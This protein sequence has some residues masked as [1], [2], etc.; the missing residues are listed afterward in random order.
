[1]SAHRKLLTRFTSFLLA[2]TMLFTFASASTDINQNGG[3]STTGVSGQ[4][5]W[6]GDSFIRVTLLFAENADWEK[7]PVYQVGR[8]VD[9]CST[10]C[11][12]EYEVKKA[13]DFSIK[14][15]LPGFEVTA[16]TAAAYNSGAPLK[17]GN[18][19]YKV[20]SE[21]LPI[22]TNAHSKGTPFP[23]L[24]GDKANGVNAEAYFSDDK[25]INQ[26][27]YAVQNASEFAGEDGGPNQGRVSN[28]KNGI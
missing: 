3:G 24:F 2:F 13:S 11:T 14:T 6:N 16:N 23:I 4:T 22:T 10:A 17:F 9:M 26:M 27:L 1:M 21:F 5:Y 28:I 8:S 19:Q 7:G 25:V 20:Q 15:S 12:D 18:Y